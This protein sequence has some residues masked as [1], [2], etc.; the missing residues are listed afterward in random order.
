[1][2]SGNKEY[3][4]LKRQLIDEAKLKLD[5]LPRESFSNR[6]MMNSS[7]V[8]IDG[9]NNGFDSNFNDIIKRRK[10]LKSS[11]PPQQ[12]SSVQKLPNVAFPGITFV[13][14]WY[15]NNDH[16]FGYGCN[17]SGIACCMKPNVTPGLF[18]ITSNVPVLREI[19]A[20]IRPSH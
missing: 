20:F 1:M 7:N 5:A 18:V 12:S 4:A 15:D 2:Y 8:E 9:N 19:C 3:F 11:P 10:T 17:S 6:L 16:I 14:E 13:Y